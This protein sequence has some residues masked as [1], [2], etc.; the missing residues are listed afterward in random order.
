M[1]VYGIPN[2]NTVKKALDWLKAN[3]IDFEFHD[4]KKKGVTAEKLNEWCKVFGWETVLNRKGLTWKKLTKEEQLEIDNQEKAITYLIQNTSAIK[5]PV[6]EKD[7]HAILISFDES[8][9][10]E[11]LG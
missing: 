11:T 10:A 2:C 7:G 8:V 3:K 6:V 5:R 4:F 9:Y 1:V